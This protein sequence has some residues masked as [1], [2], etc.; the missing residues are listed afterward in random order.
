MD[1]S[2]RQSLIC[3]AG[4]LPVHLPEVHRQTRVLLKAILPTLQLRLQWICCNA[5][6]CLPMAILSLYHTP[7]L[8]KTIVLASQYHT[9]SLLINTIR[10]YQ[11]PEHLF[12]WIAFMI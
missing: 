7:F 11:P 1:R 5:T 10:V 8:L 9:I 4:L 3:T 12:A 6:N 2:I